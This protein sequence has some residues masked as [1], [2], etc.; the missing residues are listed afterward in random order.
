MARSAP[1]RPARQR[2]AAPR[3]PAARSRSRGASSPRAPLLHRDL[4]RELTGIGAIGAGMILA[5]VL[6]LPGGGAVA[7]PLHDGLFTAFGAGAWI[8]VAGLVL[9]GSRLCLSP[10][11]RAGTRA[12]IGQCGGDG[13]PPR[14]RRDARQR[15]RHPGTLDRRR[16]ASRARWRRRRR[17]LRGDRL[18]RCH[19][20][21]RPQNRRGTA[22][23]RRVV[24]R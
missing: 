21:D 8:G 14:T 15:R 3:R 2:A 24:R 23:D 1:T 18:S 6:L 20:R 5:A 11:W 17:R 9:T 19:P 12:A 13:R 10:E 16:R 7:G 4:R 22:C